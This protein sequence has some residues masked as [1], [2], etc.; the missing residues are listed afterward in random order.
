MTFGEHLDWLK[1]ATILATRYRQ[2][3]TFNRYRLRVRFIANHPDL[4]GQEYGG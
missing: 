1:L 4:Y 3:A 2:Y